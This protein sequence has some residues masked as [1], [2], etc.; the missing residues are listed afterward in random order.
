R[1]LTAP[2]PLHVALAVA[3]SLGAI[4]VRLELQIAVGALAIAAAGLWVTGPRGRRLRAGWSRG[5][6]MGAIVLLL[7]A[8]FLFNRVVLQRSYEWHQATEYWKSRM[9]DLG[10]TA[11]A[12]LAI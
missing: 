6:T 2:S 10:L 12:A 4:Y 5:D 11:G 3:A 7:G 9:I 8:L 1:A